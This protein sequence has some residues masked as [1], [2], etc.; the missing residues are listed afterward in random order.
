MHHEYRIDRKK[1]PQNQ[2]VEEGLMVGDDEE[3][4]LGKKWLVSPSTWTRNRTFNSARTM[5][6][7]MAYFSGLSVLFR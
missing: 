7:S 6:L 4:R 3:P 5:D 2:A 1:C